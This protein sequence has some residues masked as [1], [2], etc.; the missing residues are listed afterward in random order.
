[1][2]TFRIFSLAFFVGL[3]GSRSSEAATLYVLLNDT[4]S[5]LERIDTTT[6]T[7]TPVG[8]T[9]V[10]V[11]F[12]DLANSPTPG[13]AFMVNG[14]ILGPSGVTDSSLYSLNLVTGAASLIGDMGIP[15]VF[16]LAYDPVTSKLF[17]TTYSVGTVGLYNVDMNTGA[18]SLVGPT[19]V[20]GA[21]REIDGLTYNTTT[22]SLVGYSVGF[23][24]VYT[25]N[26]TKADLTFQ[27]HLQPSGGAVN[28]NNGD[29]AYDAA[30]NLYYSDDTDGQLFMTDPSAPVFNDIRIMNNLGKV[31]GILV[32]D[33]VSTTTVPEPTS[34]IAWLIPVAIFVAW[35]S[36]IRQPA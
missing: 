34:L 15:D 6:S 25:L 31:D 26:E 9:G 30:V 27:A 20:G 2:K 7:V 33:A 11:N 28:H 36:R 24:N 35:R 12:G 17:A 1:M 3:L 22:H 16:G 21:P 8:A 14:R 23:G 13:F 4:N 19:I 18:A 29:I 10:D 5:T 32:Q